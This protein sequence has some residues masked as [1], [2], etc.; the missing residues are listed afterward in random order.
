[1]KLNRS[2]FVV[3]DLDDTLYHEDDYVISGLEAIANFVLELYC[4][5]IRSLIF[6]WKE[7]DGTDILEAICHKLKLP[8][9]AKDQFLWVYRLHRPKI[10]LSAD[11]R[12]AIDRINHQ[13]AGIAI[14]TDGRSTSQRL[15]LASL[16]LLTDFPCFISEEFES[17]KPDPK[18]FLHIMNIYPAESYL[19]IGDNPCKDF[20]SPNKLG[21]STIGIKGDNRNIH[22][23]N[24]DQLTPE[25]FPT[26]WLNHFS[27]IN[28]LLC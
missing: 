16:G 2:T 14:L 23:Q 18:R 4:Q 3:L 27:D 24:M 20:I 5:D 22:S 6:K 1:M 15:K 8:I 10:Q 26:I 9:S 21:W 12:Y 7:Q 19:Y 25:F 11:I 13:C 28:N 17:T